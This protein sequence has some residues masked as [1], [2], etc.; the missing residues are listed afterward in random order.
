VFSVLSLAK[1]GLTLGQAALT[2]PADFYRARRIEFSTEFDR[3]I[4]Q[5]GCRE[6]H[7]GNGRGRLPAS[8]PALA[9]RQHRGGAR[10]LGRGRGRCAG[11]ELGRL[12]LFA[13]EQGGGDP[14]PRR[15]GR[16]RQSD[17]RSELRGAPGRPTH[18][19][20]HRRQRLF[21]IA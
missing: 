7:R 2:I 8:R 3:L 11:H 21:E 10:G 19:R 6:S 12:Q 17:R 18:W 15:L 9:L 4:R 13:A 5:A 14:A 1:R 16:V 20:K